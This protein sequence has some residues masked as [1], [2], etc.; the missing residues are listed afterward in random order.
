MFVSA[1]EY[2]GVQNNSK[3]FKQLVELL[4][5]AK[6]STNKKRQVTFILEL[7]DIS[8]HVVKSEEG[9]YIEI[10]DEEYITFYSDYWQAVKENEVK[11]S[12]D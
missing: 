5:N 4:T 1:R 7:F 11:E 12:E 3:L 6:A 9:N 10:T 2:A 8:Y